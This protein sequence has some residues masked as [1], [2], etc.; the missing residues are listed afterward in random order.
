MSVNGLIISVLQEKTGDH[1]SSADWVLDPVELASKFSDKTK[2]I[3]VNTPHNPLGKVFSKVS[4]SFLHS[5]KHEIEK[6][7]YKCARRASI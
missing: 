2:L 1:I 5:V 4:C 7:F 3:V 6:T